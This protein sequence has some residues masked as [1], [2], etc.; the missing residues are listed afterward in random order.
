MK[1]FVFSGLL[2]SVV[3]AGAISYYA[4]SRPDGFERAA[5]MT[6]KS[7]THQT[8]SAVAAPMP[9]YEVGGLGNKRLAGG[10]AGV[11]GVAATFVLC[12]VVGKLASRRRESAENSEE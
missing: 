11:A 9:D 12:M 7:E 6:V 4:S 1:R 8:V 5:E 3:I 10:L 2:A